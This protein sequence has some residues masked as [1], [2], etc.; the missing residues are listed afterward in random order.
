MSEFA[1]VICPAFA[2]DT[3]SNPDAANPTTFFIVKTSF[4]EFYL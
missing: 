3:A 1:T 4:L 2:A